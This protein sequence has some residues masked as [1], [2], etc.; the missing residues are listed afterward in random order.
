[1]CAC[2]LLQNTFTQYA[3]GLE[4]THQGAGRNEFAVD[5]QGK[6]VI[7]WHLQKKGHNCK[8]QLKGLKIL[9]NNLKEAKG[10]NIISNTDT[11]LRYTL[12]VYLDF[13]FFI[14]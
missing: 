2:L 8:T 5:D 3:N 4:K 12:S 11:L 10:I 6:A 1:M 7:C 13:F 14:Y 9:I